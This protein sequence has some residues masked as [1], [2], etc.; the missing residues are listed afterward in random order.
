MGEIK[1]Q[2]KNLTFFVEEPTTSPSL[3]ET[4]ATD[5]YYY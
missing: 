3:D 2:Q 5:K 1:K 4:A